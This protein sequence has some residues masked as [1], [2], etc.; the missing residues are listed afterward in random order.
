MSEATHSPERYDVVVIGAGPAGLTAGMYA[1]RQGL[2]TAIVG[3]EVGGQAAWASEVENYLGWRLVTG[4]DLV[5]AFRDHVSQFD[6]KCFEGQ[7]VNAL[8]PAEDGFDV[9][10]REGAHLPT[11]A[12]IIA[13]GRAPNRLAVP[14]ET[15]MIGRGVSYCATCDGSFF[16]GQPVA[17]VGSTESACDAALELADL[18]ATVTIV[19][20]TP[21]KAHAAVLEKV[22]ASGAITVREGLKVTAIEGDERVTGLAV[23][24]VK[25]GAGEVLPVT[26]VFI[27]TGSIPVSEYTGGL[28]EI[29]EKGE[30]VTDKRCATSAS[31]IYAAGDVTDGLGK[32]IIIAAGEGARAAMAVSRDLKRR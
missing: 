26:G 20:Q 27:E 15:E 21:L 25:T 11:R 10:T 4:A 32:Q 28:V 23:K 29:N 13:T 19:T 14:G 31:G 7:L 12:V 9:Y 30:I 22:A 2:A 24:D 16:R 5:R 8:V 18:D 17:V 1:A 3:G 6:V